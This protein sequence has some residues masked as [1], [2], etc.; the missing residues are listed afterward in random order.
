[1]KKIL[2]I[3]LAFAMVISI[4]PASIAFA[5]GSEVEAREHE[6]V[7]AQEGFNTDKML[8][9]SD[10]SN[11]VIRDANSAIYCAA[12]MD[13][14]YQVAA[15]FSKDGNAFMALDTTTDDGDAKLTDKWKLV[16]NRPSAT[17][18]IFAGFFKYE[19]PMSYIG[20]VGS[21]YVVFRLRVEAPGEYDLQLKGNAV[22]TAYPAI[23]FFK[24][25]QAGVNEGAAETYPA[26]SKLGYFETNNASYKSLGKVT[27]EEAGD[28]IL[29]FMFDA[30]S[31]AKTPT[32]SNQ[33]LGIYGAKLVPIV[34]QRTYEYVTTQAA[35]DTAKIITTDDYSEKPVIRAANNAMYYTQMMSWKYEVPAAY[36]QT[37][38][39]F[40]AMDLTKTDKWEYVD[41]RLFNNPHI[42]E[43]YYKY[44]APTSGIDSV[45]AS[46]YSVFRLNIDAPGE[47]ELQLKGHPAE[48]N[49]FPAI[50]FFKDGLSGVHSA[51]QT[52]Y[53]V[54]SKL[55]YFDSSS[56]S[57]ISMG[58]VN[59]TEPGDYIISFMFDDGS[60]E[61]LPDV[62]DHFLTLSGIKLVPNIPDEI[63]SISITPA[64]GSI[65]K[66]STTTLTAKAVWTVSGEKA[67][68]LD[69]VTLTSSNGNVS[70][71]ADG[72]VTGLAVGS[73]TI[74][75]TLK[76]D[77]SIK[78]TA[79]IEVLTADLTYDFRVSAE[80]ANA[81]GK[82][83]IMFTS[84]PTM[85]DFMPEGISTNW[86]IGTNTDKAYNGYG[87]FRWDV[88]RGLRFQNICNDWLTST[89]HYNRATLDIEISADRAGWYRPNILFDDIGNA[90]DSTYRFAIYMISGDK[91]TYLGEHSKAVNGTDMNPVYLGKGT[92]TL[93]FGFYS[94]ATR[95]YKSI[96]LHK[97]TLKKLS[98]APTVATFS[99]NIPSSVAYGA[100]ADITVGNATMSDGGALAFAT[101]GSNTQG[102]NAGL[103]TTG[104]TDYIK[105]ESSNAAVATVA[106]VSANKW[107]LTAVNDGETTITVTP[108]FNGVAQTPVHTK[109][110]SVTYPNAS[111][112]YNPNF[113]VDA[114][115]G[116]EGFSAEARALITSDDLKIGAIDD[117]AL[118]SM[119][120]LEAKSN[121][122]YKFLYWY[123][124]NSK[125]ILSD[126]EEYKFQVGTKA[127]IYAKY[128]RV[129]DEL[130]EYA[131]AAGQIVDSLDGETKTK[132]I[133]SYYTLIYKEAAAAASTLVEKTATLADFV[134]WLKD[135]QI[136]SYNENYS[137]Y[138]W[139]N[140]VD[141]DE[142]TEGEK[143]NVPAVVLFEDGN[144]Y[145]LELVNF[146]GKT[147]VEKG[148]LFANGGTPTV[149]SFG[150]KAVA[151]T[152]KAQFTASTD[153]SVARAYV[154]YLDGGKY[155]VAYSD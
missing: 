47:Y 141:A 86:E 31:A 94:T 45:G 82:N 92:H 152:D 115:V 68:E 114:V 144:A 28:Y 1:M 143:S 77:S 133:G 118:G 108:Y 65:V 117:A 2:S 90:Y 16:T 35:F 8:V 57:Y 52:T 149:D 53:P 120:K 129:G 140:A 66:G 74:T 17:P 58:K 119:V 63:K 116:T 62:T 145:M 34:P 7:F 131:T 103:D 95:D 105:V 91:V 111:V 136:V 78:A 142:V 80:A 48:G 24:D 64:A 44:V 10:Y 54:G 41:A 20:G 139:G 46:G 3:I 22:S 27:V 81:A 107:T 97:L 71:A 42:L 69:D 18:H 132:E 40:M 109:T 15:E 25:G 30:T 61:R 122:T 29:S 21:S 4:F 134:C 123:N 153:A 155:R 106:R 146:E 138:T 85:D 73:S 9:R 93:V 89:D 124:G 121:D 56:D 49:S 110:V 60:K 135:G 87:A 96:W 88:G 104:T 127:A 36:S 84:D 126:A 37:G 39:A 128:A 59:V 147:I 51:S 32:L 83:A 75:A 6:F 13:W 23:Y 19:P 26:N 79:N 11:P 98:S 12:A 150:A 67:L 72:T 101:Y 33:L 151:T 55:G 154:I 137:F 112:N 130:V 99:A 50:Y 113:L 70:V 43:G 102:D 14:Q 5:A 125:V 38:A 148:I 100:T 76:A